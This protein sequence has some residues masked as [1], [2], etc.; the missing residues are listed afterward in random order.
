MSLDVVKANEGVV[1]SIGDTDLVMVCASGGSLKPISFENLMKAVR[2]EIKIGGRNYAALSTATLMNA[3]VEG[4]VLKQVV[5]DTRPN[6][7]LQV[8]VFDSAHKQTA[9]YNKTIPQDGRY[10]VS[11]NVPDGTAILY[12]KHNGQARDFGV[13]FAFPYSGQFLIGLTIKASSSLY[14]IS[15][16]MVE[17][18]DVASD[19][20]PAPEDIASGAWG[21]IGLFP[22]TYNSVEKGGAHES[23]YEDLNCGAEGGADGH[24]S[25]RSLDALAQFVGRACEEQVCEDADAAR[26]DR[27]DVRCECLDRSGILHAAVICGEHTSQSVP[28]LDEGDCLCSEHIPACRREEKHSPDP[29][30]AD[31]YGRPVDWLDGVVQRTPDCYVADR[32]EVAY[33]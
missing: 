17:R 1:S 25:F 30:V 21:V 27:K 31:V 23:R 8:T 14:E 24:L 5:A 7:Q 11:V 15:D 22:I 4:S 18:A 9:L 26:D 32:K 20:T 16:I 3:T 10:F 29:D 28:D 12:V 2:G 19:W 33:V 13:R 6:F